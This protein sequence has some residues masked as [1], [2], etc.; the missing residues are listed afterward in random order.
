MSLTNL[1]RHWRHAAE[2]LDLSVKIPFV[3]TFDDGESIEAEV[4]LQGYGATHGMLIVSD[5]SIVEGRHEAI[6]SK[7]YG[8]SCMSQPEESAITCLEGFDELLADWTAVGERK[9]TKRRTKR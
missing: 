6:V 3:L 2:Q 4:L 1:Q 5:S 7:G 8:Y 9:Q